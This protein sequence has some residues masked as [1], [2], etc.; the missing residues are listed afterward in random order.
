MNPKISQY[1]S[2]GCSHFDKAAL[3]L[4]GF[5]ALAAN[6]RRYGRFSR[7]TSPFHKMWLKP[8]QLRGSRLLIDPN[9]WSQVVIFDEI[10]LQSGYDMSKVDFIPDV[11]IDCGA[12]VGMFSIFAA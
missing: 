7:L 11:I 3:G 5:A 12:H 2:L 1:A 4:F 6:S 9:D 8:R 10:F